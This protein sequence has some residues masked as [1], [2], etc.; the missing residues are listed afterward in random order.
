MPLRRE[1]A[2]RARRLVPAVT[3]RA[4]AADVG[5]CGAVG[6]GAGAGVP[7]VCVEEPPPCRSGARP[8]PPHERRAPSP[9]APGDPTQQPIAGSASLPLHLSADG[10]CTA[11]A[12]LPRCR[13]AAPQ[14]FAVLRCCAAAPQVFA[15][16]CGASRGMDLVR[17]VAARRGCAVGRS[18]SR[19]PLA[20][21][22]AYL[23]TVK[24]RRA[25]LRSRHARRRRRL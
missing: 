12:A 16:R 5:R 18:D 10:R 24:R 25:T 4:A 11:A 13:A 23:G 3:G 17:S 8:C 9:P 20:A 19:V 22:R 6:L 7:R 15:V 2:L 1:R 21:R 14:V